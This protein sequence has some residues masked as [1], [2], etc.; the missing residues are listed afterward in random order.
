DL[1][2]AVEG[3]PGPDLLATVERSAAH[4]AAVPPEELPGAVHLAFELEAAVSDPAVVVVRDV[5]RR[6]ARR[7]HDPIIGRSGTLRPDA[8]HPSPRRRPRPPRL[9]RLRRVAPG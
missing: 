6:L 8:P 7:W 2:I 1:P 9:G 3:P 5:R 4:D